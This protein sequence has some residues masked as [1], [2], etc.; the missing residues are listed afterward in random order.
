[1]KTQLLAASLLLTALLAGCQ[2]G[3]KQAEA[4]Q[5]IKVR[6]ITTHAEQTS[7]ARRYSGTVEE[8]NGT[9]LSFST[10]GTVKRIYVHLGQRVAAGQLIAVL[11]SAS[12]RSSYQAARATL[13][14]AEDAYRR[15]KE[16]HDKGS[17]PD[18]KWVEAESRLAQARS[19]EQ[20]ARKS[21]SDCRLYAPFA[22]VIAEKNAE[23]GQNV[24]PGAPVARL[25]TTGQLKVKIAV[26][27]AEIGRCPIGG[28]ATV[29]VPA[30]GNRTFRARIAE[31]G[32]VANPLSRSYEVKLRVVQADKALLPGMIAEVSLP[33]EGSGTN[34]IVPAHIV[35]IDERNRS[36]VWVA[37]GGKAEKRYITCGDFAGEGVAVTQGLKE[38]EQVLVEGQHKV[39]NGTA[40]QVIE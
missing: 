5:P 35:Q 23:A 19:M 27:E 28:E 8:E 22:G 9:L 10:A 33:G 32:I 21:L 37:A 11:D 12:L 13:E 3:E 15:M 39:C 17:L 7:A 6:T 29:S 16:L 40:L 24:M 36:F 34:C 2:R 25:V 38:G 31:K 1:M 26:P 4:Q 20:I 18:I 14:Q 30:L